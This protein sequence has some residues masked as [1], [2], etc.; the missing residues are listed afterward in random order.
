MLILISV[1]N[2]SSWQKTRGDTKDLNKT[3]NQLDLTGF[4]STPLNN[5]MVNIQVQ[6]FFFTY[7]EYSLGHEPSI[8]KFWKTQFI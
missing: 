7:T 2:G 4:Y 5:N 6:I 1:I 3:I 8:N